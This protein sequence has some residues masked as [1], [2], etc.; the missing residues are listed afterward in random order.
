MCTH[1]VAGSHESLVQTLPSSQ[2]RVFAACTHPTAGSHESVVQAL[3]SSQASGGPPWHAPSAHVSCAVQ[4]FPSS[5]AAVLGAMVQSPVAGSQES[6]VQT[7]PSSQLRAAV[8]TQ[9]SA[10]SH[11]SVVHT[12][13]SLQLRGGP[14]LH[15]PPP[16]TSR[17]LHTVPSS[18]GLVLLTCWQPLTASHESVVHT[19]LSLQSSGAPPTQV[20]VAQVSPAVQALPS[21]HGFA[22]KPTT[23]HVPVP[24]Q[25]PSSVQT[26]ASLQAQPPCSK[27]Q[28]AEQQSPL[29]VLPS[30]HSS[31]GST[32]PLPQRAP[33]ASPPLPSPNLAPVICA[34]RK[35]TMSSCKGESSASN[36]CAAATAS[37]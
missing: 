1:P 25:V 32:T 35:A 24:L 31:P 18:H 37:E 8:W 30:S 33:T 23:W 4:G 16:Q 3:P 10:G 7:L 9:P 17:P 21:W 27:K 36:A 2:A 22:L 11:E 29:T 34:R 13:L 12:L 28:S 26:L 20:P 6:V 5:H 15:V 19:L 14:G